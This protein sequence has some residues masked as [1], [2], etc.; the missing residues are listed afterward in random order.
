MSELRLRVALRELSLLVVLVVHL[1]PGDA[2]VAELRLGGVAEAE[3][4][5]A[6]HVAEW[7]GRGPGAGTEPEVRVVDR[8][9]PRA[10]GA[11]GLGCC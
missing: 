5:H 2:R 1:L 8:R 11:P 3:R 6:R 4:L 9:G 7:P 10:A